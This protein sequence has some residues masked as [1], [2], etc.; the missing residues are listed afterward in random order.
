MENFTTADIKLQAF[1]RTMK[2][3]AF[4][5][6]ERIGSSKVFF[7][8]ERDSHLDLLVNGYYMGKPFTFSP[9][10]FSSNLDKAKQLIFQD[11]SSDGST[12]R[13]NKYE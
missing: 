6:I 3:Q 4:L 9:L 13:G 5:G 2:P 1:L 11:Y 10:D 7:L 12:K 8:F